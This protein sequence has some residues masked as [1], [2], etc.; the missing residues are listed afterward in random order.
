MQAKEKRIKILDLQDQHCKRCNYYERT[1]KF[2]VNKCK[3]GNE[4]YQLGIRLFENEANERREKRERW[5][6]ICR[7]AITMREEGMS[8]YRIAKILDCDS[9]S[10][11]KYLKKENEKNH[12][13]L[14]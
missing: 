5:K 1:Y 10:L 2:C 6:E 11:Y 8:Y 4:I 7:R 9:G 13:L 14:R 3:I 12:L